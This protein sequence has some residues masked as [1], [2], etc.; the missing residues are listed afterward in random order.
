MDWLR[1]TATI[2][3][4]TNPAVSAEGERCCLS[5]CSLKIGL[6]LYAGAIVAFGWARLSWF[7]DFPR[8]TRASGRGVTSLHGFLRRNRLA[9]LVP[10]KN[11][12]HL[13][14]GEFVSELA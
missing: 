14:F 8:S 13:K 10:E 9:A 1:G 11:V 7:L 3:K 12:D 4:C 5:H 6:L 2:A